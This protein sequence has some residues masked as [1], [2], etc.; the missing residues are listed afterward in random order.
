M[1][2][3]ERK[4]KTNNSSIHFQ[5]KNGHPKQ[6]KEK[7]HKLRLS[8]LEAKKASKQANLV[9]VTS[10]LEMASSNKAAAAILILVVAT[11]VISS[12]YADQVQDG[13]AASQAQQYIQASMY[14]QSAEAQEHG[15][16]AEVHGS[17]RHCFGA[18]NA[19]CINPYSS[20]PELTNLC[21]SKCKA[22]CNL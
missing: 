13:G 17:S 15:D 22:Q 1:L 20:E 21:E 10:I 16:N 3:W 14:A 9:N 6:L 11:T 4:D 5:A 8:P 18:C 12:C 2:F 7:L 19:G